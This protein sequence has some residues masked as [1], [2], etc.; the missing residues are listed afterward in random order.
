MIDDNN[1]RLLIDDHGR[2]I[3][4][5]FRLAA[6]L[7]SQSLFSLLHDFIVELTSLDRLSLRVIQSFESFRILRLTNLDRFWAT[8]LIDDLLL[9]WLRGLNYCRLLSQNL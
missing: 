1:L 7:V 2:L 4:R 6:M 8:L 9:S 3:I 5:D